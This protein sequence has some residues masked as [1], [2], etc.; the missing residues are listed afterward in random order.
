MVYEYENFVM[1]ELFSLLIFYINI[2]TIYLF[3]YLC[4]VLTSV[5]NYTSQISLDTTYL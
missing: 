2:V 1:P 5:K 4:H 3:N